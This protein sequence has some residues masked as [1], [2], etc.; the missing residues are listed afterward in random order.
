MCKLNGLMANEIE[1]VDKNRC[2]SVQV[3]EE[4]IEKADPITCRFDLIRK[5]SNLRFINET[6]IVHTLRS[7]FHANLAHTYAGNGLV[8]LKPFVENNQYRR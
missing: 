2:L 6:S 4:H 3:D 5:M 7:R 8:V 1:L